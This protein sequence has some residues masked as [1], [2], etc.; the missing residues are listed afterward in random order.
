MLKGTETRRPERVEITA[1]KKKPLWV[2]FKEY[3]NSLDENQVFTRGNLFD[4]IYEEKTSLAV[5]GLETSVDHYRCY[6]C[7]IGFLDHIKTG[8]YRKKHSIPD[9]MTVTMMKNWAYNN[10]TWKDWFSSDVSMMETVQRICEV[11]SKKK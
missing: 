5:R 7:R 11:K 1:K 2:L 4:A 6:A 8:T 9:N 10:T 3:I